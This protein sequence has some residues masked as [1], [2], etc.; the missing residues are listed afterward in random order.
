VNRAD[1]WIL[2]T[3]ITGTTLPR[4]AD[5]TVNVA[6]ETHLLLREETAY[7]FPGFYQLWLASS[8]IQARLGNAPAAQRSAR[9]A[10]AMFSDVGRYLNHQ[11]YLASLLGQDEEARGFYEQALPV[12]PKDPTAPAALARHW[13]VQDDLDRAVGY[14]EEA[15][16]R[17]PG[18][19]DL[20]RLMGQLQAACGNQEGALEYS[21][22]AL[23]INPRY[24]SARIEEA[25]A[26]FLLNRWH[27][28]VFTYRNL[29][30]EGFRSSDILLH[31]GRCE[32]ECGRFRDAERAYLESVDMN[33]EELL[34]HYRLSILYRKLGRPEAADLTWNLALDLNRRPEVRNP[35]ESLIESQGFTDKDWPLPAEHHAA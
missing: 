12:A 9:M 21:R 5:Q 6:G 13:S 2:S 25:N 8:R 18:Y 26:L 28:A 33:P 4:A 32:E 34:A 24:R 31:L 11:G 14:L 22:R 7:P 30:G 35:V 19:A 27:D 29:V 3:R 17:A 23:K 15:L 1:A 16:R 20:H 10:F